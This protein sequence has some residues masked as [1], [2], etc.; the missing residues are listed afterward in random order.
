LTRQPGPPRRVG[1]FGGTFDPP[2]NAHL[3]LA[4]SA[5]EALQLDE[6]RWI[7]AGQPW[8]KARPITSA[9][10]REAMVRLAIDGQPRFVLDRIE[11]ERDGPSYT[12]DT[13]RALGAVQASDGTVPQLFLIIGTDQYAGLHTWHG[14]Q[15]ILARVTLAVANRP[16]PMP[17]VDAQVLR[18]PHRVVPLAMLDISATDIR[19]R[20][21]RGE[22]IDAL[23]PPAVARYIESHRLYRN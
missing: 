22:S 21:A 18:H 20:V 14:W 16:G 10:H 8:Q 1:V 7:P 15:D 3:A 9:T 17:P 4:R 5:V 12:L 13:V 6:L 23:V 2:H 11:I 19:A